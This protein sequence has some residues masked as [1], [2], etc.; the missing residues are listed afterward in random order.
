MQPTESFEMAILSLKNNN[1]NYQVQLWDCGTSY[2]GL[3]KYLKGSLFSNCSAA[4][5][6]FDLCDARWT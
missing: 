6:L 1:I 3:N 2:G 5:I 4:F